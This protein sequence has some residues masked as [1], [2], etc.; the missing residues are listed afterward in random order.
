[1]GSSFRMNVSSYESLQ[2]CENIATTTVYDYYVDIKEVDYKNSVFSNDNVTVYEGEWRHE[3]VCVKVV[4]TN[5]NMINELMVL[6]KCIHP[7]I[8]QF[9]GFNRKDDLT[10]ILFEYMGNGN[11]QDYITEHKDSLTSLNK[12]NM[13]IDITKA[14]HY[15]HNRYPDV[16]LHRDIKPSNVLVDDRGRVKLSDFGISKLV[17]QSKSVEYLGHSPE[18]GT[19][20]WMSP[21]T[22]KGEEYN[23]N[24]DIYSLG[25]L[26][27]FIWSGGRNPYEC[28]KKLS[29][30][31][32]MFKKINNTL[33]IRSTDNFN[34]LNQ[35]ISI[36]THT[37][38]TL[39]PNTDSILTELY[40][41]MEKI[42]IDKNQ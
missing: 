31:Q 2:L 1:M 5:D 9:L 20:T 7:K 16:V 25:L 13:M 24:T 15:L 30:V 18:K 11:L 42:K 10:Y 3:R 36:C 23:T 29:P 32:I 38:K 4:K 17:Q 41:I 6:S 33:K 14:L 40:S 12:V 8:V 26:F 35:L 34:Q 28:V 27:Y 37:D 39:R 22:L 19:Y 21:E